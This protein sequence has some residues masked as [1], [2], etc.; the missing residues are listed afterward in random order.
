[1]P[2]NGEIYILQFSHCCSRFR[3]RLGRALS[4]VLHTPAEPVFEQGLLRGTQKFL[5]ITNLL[6]TDHSHYSQCWCHSCEV[7]KS[8]E[9]LELLLLSPAECHPHCHCYDGSWPPAEQGCHWSH[10]LHL[11]VSEQLVSPEIT[12]LI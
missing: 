6:L 5:L 10:N 3:C 11:C 1:M 4:Q 2:L 7:L 12:N 9:P 8:T